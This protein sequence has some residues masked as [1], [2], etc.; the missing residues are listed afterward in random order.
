MGIRPYYLSSLA[1]C[2]TVAGNHH[3][4]LLVEIRHVHRLD[5]ASPRFAAGPMIPIR[6][7]DRDD[8]RISH[9]DLQHRGGAGC[10]DRS[11]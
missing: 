10:R 3:A 8:L 5:L 11:R 7:T 1:V 6:G 2:N 9:S 4:H